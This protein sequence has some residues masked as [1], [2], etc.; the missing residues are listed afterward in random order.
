MTTVLAVPASHG[1]AE[2]HKSSRQIIDSLDGTIDKAYNSGD[3]LLF[4]SIMSSVEEDG[5]QVRHERT[6]VVEDQRN[7]IALLF[8]FP[9]S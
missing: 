4:E 1:Q 8:F 9:S 7:C 2:H 5:V 6:A 3:L